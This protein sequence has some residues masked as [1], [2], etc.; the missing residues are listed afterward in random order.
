[1]HSP[2]EIPH[3]LSSMIRSYLLR[4]PPFVKISIILSCAT[5]NYFPSYVGFPGFSPTPEIDL[6]TPS[7]KIIRIRGV[8]V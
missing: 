4:Y 8:S 3:P 1:M 7:V 6:L 2:C 5:S